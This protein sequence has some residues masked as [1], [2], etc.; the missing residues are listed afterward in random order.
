MR[1]G[2]LLMGL[3]LGCSDPG[4]PTIPPRSVIGPDRPAATTCFPPYS[5]FAQAPFVLADLNQGVSCEVYLEQD[6]CV[7]GIFKDCTDLS[8]DPRQWIGTIDSNMMRD[9]LEFAIVEGEGSVISQS[10]S[11]CRGE[12]FDSRW[13]MMDCALTN[14]SNTT[15]SV[16]VGTYLELID[17]TI[18]A[19]GAIGA[20]GFV[21]ASGTVE[22]FVY[23]QKSP[24]EI[25]ALTRNAVAVHEI[26]GVTQ[27]LQPTLMNGSRIVL[28]DHGNTA[29]VADGSTLLRFD[30]QTR[31]IEESVDLGARI[32]VLAYS[33]NG[34][35]VGIQEGTDTRLTLR[36][37]ADLNTVTA[38]RL[39][40]RLNDITLVREGAMDA[41]WVA[42]IEDE[43]LLVLT[44]SLSLSDDQPIVKPARKV[45]PVD[46]RV[47]GF[48]A[49]CSETSNKAHCYFEW[50]MDR[51]EVRRA[52]FPNVGDIRDIVV[53]PM[54]NAVLAVGTEPRLGILDRG[55]WRPLVQAQFE[56][57]EGNRL[58]RDDSTGDLIL[59]SSNASFQR[60]S[61]R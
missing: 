27:I 48:L 38:D 34:I 11:C 14:C 24:P 1:W 33:P 36:R 56:V 47:V 19:W 29:Y 25:W 57:M 40:P 7:L 52:G 18:P 59:V 60:I 55:Q 61:P 16:H 5:D 39:H 21:D 44:S 32:D 37:T 31:T 17:E 35:A 58:R 15:D 20:V 10:P 50:R 53:D 22:E 51:G 12:L 42:A 30:T 23:V 45:Y 41:T 2:V 46:D 6:E 43:K 13:A 28:A 26:G 9:M 54:R 8:P 49:Q 4:P 3:S